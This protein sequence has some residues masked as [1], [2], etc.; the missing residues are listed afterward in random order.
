M[1]EDT[2]LDGLISIKVTLAFF[3]KLREPHCPVAK[4]S[5][6]AEIHDLRRKTAAGTE[7]ETY[8]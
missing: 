7:V 4:Q 1:S 2:H 8:A 5:S 6:T 3:N